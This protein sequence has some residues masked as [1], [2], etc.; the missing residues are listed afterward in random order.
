MFEMAQRPPRRTG[1]KALAALGTAAVMTVGFAMPAAVADPS[2]S[3]TGTGPSGAQV[4]VAPG[5]NL[6]ADGDSTLSLTGSGFA[7]SNNGSSFGGAYLLF[8]VVTPKDASDE[9][10][11]TPSAGGLIGQNYDYAPGA[12][13]YQSMV[14]YPGNTTEPGLPTMDAD[15]NWSAELTIPGAVFESQMGNEIDCFVD[16]CGVITIGAHGQRNAGVEAFVPV[17]FEEESTA[18]ETTV[19]VAPQPVGDFPTYFLGEEESLTA[20][21]SPAEATGSVEFFDGD[22]SLGTAEVADGEATLTTDAW[23]A[24]GP[25]AITAQFTSDSEQFLGSESS[26]R[27]YVVVDL[28]R[29]I[30]DI[31]LGATVAEGEGAQLDW[32]IA[33]MYNT[34]GYWFDKEAID[35]NVSVPETVPG[36]PYE[37]TNRLFTFSEGIAQQDA[38]GNTVISFEGTARITSGSANQW[39]F[40]D[41]QVHVNAAGDGYI[42]ADFSGYFTVEGM[43]DYQYGPGRTT[44][45]TFSG[46][47]VTADENGQVS[48][49]IAPNWE[50]E[51]DEGTW[52]GGIDASYPNEF[53]AQIYSG[54]R[55][56]FYGSGSSGDQ[57]KK[58]R[59]FTLSY[60]TEEV[61]IAPSIVTDPADVVAAPGEDVELSAEVA[62]SPEPTVQWQQLTDGEWVDVDG[63]TSTTYAFTAAAEQDGAQF[64]IVATNEA[65]SAES[66]AATVTVTSAAVEAAPEVISHPEDVTAKL[67]ER[68]T[69]ETIVTGSPAPVA[70]WQ[71]LAAGADEWVNVGE[72]LRLDQAD[73]ARGAQPTA[74]GL[75]QYIATLS[76]TVDESVADAQFRISL[77]NEFG[78]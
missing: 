76:F 53:T 21:V 63:A 40:K 48:F 25:R 18:V 57:Y 73:T 46:A 50:G 26:S 43:A 19:T 35:G 9:H 47:D 20:S 41:V 12:G 75:P 30:A 14:S 67:G 8:G 31:E 29:S 68:V 42:T 11:W 78:E 72:E 65:G 52:A 32:T 71:M 70:Q 28:A 55:S 66:A 74:D 62:G 15:G 59:P 56:F 2:G 64:R 17:T 37:N 33:N 77:V 4:N 16:Q 44:I 69:L 3:S 54:V 24:G 60:S 51:T 39:N 38:D 36:E 10:S 1:A 27:S 7:T 22:T 23:V 5:E 34:V 45:A 6:V 13:L 58:P 61:A 49:E